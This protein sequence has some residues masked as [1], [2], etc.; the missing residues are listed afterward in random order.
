MIALSPVR[1]PS[2]THSTNGDK[3]L[4]RRAFVATLGAAALAAGSG[5]AAPQKAAG[6]GAAAPQKAA[7]VAAAPEPRFVAL[8]EAATRAGGPAKA[9]LRVCFERLSAKE[10]NFAEC[11]RLASDLVAGTQ[12]LAALAATGA[13]FAAGFAKTIADIAIACRKECEKFPDVA[14]FKACGAAAAML[15]EE[16]GKVTF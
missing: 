9:C 1:R 14:V 15:A 12:T 13:P 4:Q 2:E 10:T 3:P 16:C 5:A 6:S 7:P 11:A 8:A